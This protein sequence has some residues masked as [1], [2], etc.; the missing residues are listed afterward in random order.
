MKLENSLGNRKGKR[1]QPNLRPLSSPWPISLLHIPNLAA[2]LPF[3]AALLPSPVRSVL[4]LPGAGPSRAWPNSPPP[5]ALA[6]PALRVA[7]PPARLPLPLSANVAAQRLSAVRSPSPSDKAVPPGSE[8]FTRSLAL[9]LARPRLPLADSLGPP[10]S[11]SSSSSRFPR[12][13]P[14]SAPPRSCREASLSRGPQPLQDPLAAS[15]ARSTSRN[16]LTRTRD[17]A[18]LLRDLFQP[19]PSS[20]EIPGDHLPSP[21]RR[22]PR[23]YL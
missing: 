21:E 2:H 8:P 11:P 16:F 18:R 14:D 6:Q 23:P 3:P 1:I 22:D 7:S 13:A 12:R 9:H 20:A 17:R 15:R 10:V 5:S 4:P 19:R